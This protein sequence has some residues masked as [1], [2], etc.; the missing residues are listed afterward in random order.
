[1]KI[2]TIVALVAILTGCGGGGG[3]DDGEQT[4]ANQDFHAP[5]PVLV[6]VP[7][8]TEA[9]KTCINNGPLDIVCS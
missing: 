6:V 1:M 4:Q 5:P 3:V 8:E 9:P 2:F 7:A